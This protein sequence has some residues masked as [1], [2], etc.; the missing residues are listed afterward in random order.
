MS[1]RQGYRLRLRFKEMDIEPSKE[2]SFDYV[3]VRGGHL[4]TATVR[5]R[6]CGQSLPPDVLTGE[7]IWLLGLRQF[8]SLSG[9]SNLMTGV[10]GRMYAFIYY[11]FIWLLGL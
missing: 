1:A 6:F 9:R 3:E 5:G 7:L 2:C 10:Y 11:W 4:A 8:Q